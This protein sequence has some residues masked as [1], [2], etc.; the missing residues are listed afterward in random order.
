LL[1]AYDGSAVSIAIG[2]V[3]I[4]GDSVD[5]LTEVTKAAL[6]G[7]KADPVIV[8]LASIGLAL[9][10]GTGGTADITAPLTA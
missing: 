7:K 3:P 8:V 2:F 5:L 9:D 10:I 1:K 6:L 4:L